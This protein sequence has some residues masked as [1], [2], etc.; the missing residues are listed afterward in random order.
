M[1]MLPPPDVD[2]LEGAARDTQGCDHGGESVI[3]DD[4]TPQRRE[5]PLAGAVR[6]CVR[7]Q[8]RRW[9]CWKFTK[10]LFLD[11]DTSFALLPN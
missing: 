9:R 2:P 4:I 1:M 3:C 8:R 11:E 7:P 5:L 6:A 10:R